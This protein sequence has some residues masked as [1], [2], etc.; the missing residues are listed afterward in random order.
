MTRLDQH[1]VVAQE[2]ARPLEIVER[3]RL[4]DDI[5]RQLEQD[6]AELVR[7]A[8]RRQALPEVAELARLEARATELKDTIVATETE[9]GD[10]SREQNRAERDVEQ[11]R[12]R[13]EKLLGQMDLL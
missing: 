12:T 2:V 7:L 1:C 13:I 6:P 5:R 8:R 11:V 4:P 3:R 9:L 10:L